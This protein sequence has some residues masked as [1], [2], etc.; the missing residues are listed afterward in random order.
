M[1][2]ITRENVFLLIRMKPT[3]EK[4]RIRI[5]SQW[6]ESAGTDLYQNNTDPQHQRC[7]SGMFKPEFRIRFPSRI[8]RFR[9]PEPDSH[10]RM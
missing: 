2:S 10:Q 5:L 8:K 4:S 6:Y 3:N 9:I 1:S 7:G